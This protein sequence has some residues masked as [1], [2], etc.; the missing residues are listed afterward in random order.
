MSAFNDTNE[1]EKMIAPSSLLATSVIPEPEFNPS[2]TGV[3][4]TQEH[5]DVSSEDFAPTVT[6]NLCGPVPLDNTATPPVTEPDF[7]SMMLR[8]E[9]NISLQTRAVQD[10]LAAQLEDL[11]AERAA[12]REELQAQA[13]AQ[14]KMMFQMQE[15]LLKLSLNLKTL[16]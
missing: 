5:D 2:L 1:L 4:E 8:L 15:T 9:S 3:E 13:A 6:E 12:E 14:A 16:Y 10:D 11:H 7:V